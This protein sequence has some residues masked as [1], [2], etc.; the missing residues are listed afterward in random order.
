MHID[1]LLS[2]T[3]LGRFVFSYVCWI[4][5]GRHGLKE[6][7][8]ERSWARTNESLRSTVTQITTVVGILPILILW[9]QLTYLFSQQGLVLAVCAAFLTTTPPIQALDYT[10]PRS[11]IWLFLGFGVSI[12]GLFCQLLFFDS[13]RYS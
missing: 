5:I 11:Y 1:T 6:H 7:Q 9:Y 10:F 3:R 2:N 8:D 4:S 13:T 12:W